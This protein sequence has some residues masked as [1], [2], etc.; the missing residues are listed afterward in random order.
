MNLAI[1]SGGYGTTTDDTDTTDDSDTSDSSSTTTT[2]TTD[3]SDSYYGIPDG[4]SNRYCADTEE[5]ES[6]GAGQGNTV[7]DVVAPDPNE[8][9]DGDEVTVNE[10]G[11]VGVDVEESTMTEDEIREGV[12]DFFDG[13]SNEQATETAQ[14][15]AQNVNEALASALDGLQLPGL[16]ST[17]G[18]LSQKQVA[19]VVIVV[20]AA[21]VAVGR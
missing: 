18:S 19:A 10:D 16:T 17:G 4:C 20:V 15:A 12:A 8:G 6:G 5:A 13:G 21:A 7:V 9:S 3:T 11:S 2:T 1:D 14:N